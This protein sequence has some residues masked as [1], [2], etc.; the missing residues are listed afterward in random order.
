MTF[1]YIWQML[2]S[3]V[4]DNKDIQT[5]QEVE[6]LSRVTVNVPRGYF[7]VFKIRCKYVLACVNHPEAGLTMAALQASNKSLQS[8]CEEEREV[9]YNGFTATFTTF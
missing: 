2:L 5:Q 1:H 4:A 3:N 9:V 7:S 8:C 6:F